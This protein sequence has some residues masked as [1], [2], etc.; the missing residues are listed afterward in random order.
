MIQ[1]S[2][3]A[4]LIIW[5]ISFGIGAAQATF[6]PEEILKNAEPTRATS[7]VTEEQFNQVVSEIQNTFQPLASAMGATLSISGDWKSTQLNAGSHETF[8]HWWNVYITGAIARRPE[9][10]VDGVALILCHEMGH[11]LGGFP[12]IPASNPFDSKWAAAEG[13]A[14]YF[15]TQVCPHKIWGQAL[16]ENATFRDKVSSEAKTQCDGVWSTQEERD[17]CYRVSVGY[18]SI[19]ATMAGLMHKPVPQIGTPDPTVVAKTNLYYPSIQCRMDT[20]FQGSL[21]KA[22]YIDGIIPGKKAKGGMDSLDAEQ[23]ASESSCMKSSGYSVGLRP[24]CW[25]KA[26]L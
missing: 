9:N 17:L 12:F 26:R 20:L 19:I 5:G 7:S 13:E 14:D 21:C 2:G 25:F 4:G 16:A 8:G 1:L 10:T 11:H 6:L 23:Q 22:T 18:S 15:S 3:V 24:A